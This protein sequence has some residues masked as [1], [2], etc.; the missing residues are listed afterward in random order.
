ME[1][2]KSKLLTWQD[3]YTAAAASYSAELDRMDRRE[4][5]YRGDPVIYDTNGRATKNKAT[6][7]R[8]VAQEIIETEID[9]NIPQP[10]VTALHEEDEGLAKL[11]EDL[12]RNELD[13]LPTERLNDEAERICPIQGGNGFLGEWDNRLGGHDT[14]G[15][16][17]VKLQHP[18]RIIPQDGIYQVEE[19]DWFFLR[20]PQ[21]K[22]SIKRRY[23]KDVE[24]EAE[25]D[26]EVKSMEGSV[27]PDMVTMITAYYRSSGG[28]IGRYSWVGDTELEDLE[29][30]QARRVY[31]CKKCGTVGDGE[32]CREC[33]G[34]T[35]DES[36]EEDLELTEDIRRSDGSVIPALSPK[37]DEFGQPVFETIGAPEMVQP[38][39]TGAVLLQQP[40]GYA[41]VGVMGYQQEPVME[42]TRIPYYKPNIYPLVLRK[43]VSLFGKFLGASDVDAIESQQNTMNKLSTKINRKVL[44]SGSF[45]TKPKN[46]KFELTDEDNLTLNVE[47]A[48]DAEMIKAINTQANIANDMALRSEIYEEARQQIGITDSFQ[49]RKDATATSAVAKEFSASQAAGR[50]ESKKTMKQAAFADLFE[51]MFKLILAY[52]DEPRPVLAYNEQ[53]QREY[54]TFDKWDFLKQDAAGVWYWNDAFLFSCDSSAPLASNREAMW[55]EARMNLQTGAYGDQKDPETLALFWSVMEKLHYPMAT[56]ALEK[57][58]ERVEKQKAAAEMQQKMLQAQ[59]AAGT[60]GSTV[61]TAPAAQTGQEETPAV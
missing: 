4:M 29:D 1:N 22:L 11:I 42:P 56:V 60:G 9:S 53:G 19:M 41:P 23:D 34:T 50:M 49:G 18:K 39:D 6:H 24:N 32:K 47:S 44:G 51:L 3:R 35:F 54:H 16:V 13:R 40:G 21:T 37:R 10:K 15:D 7:V 33:G 31:I 27:S 2:E 59:M 38:M 8:N 30:Y 14:I 43:N 26:T 12:L 46:A 61:P 20:T 25:T 52:A 28:G 45:V 36:K 55:K 17:S 5:R 57:A 48:A 58:Q